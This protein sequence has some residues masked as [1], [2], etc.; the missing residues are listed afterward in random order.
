M[1]LVN[2]ASE[3]I[4]QIYFQRKKVEDVAQWRDAVQLNAG[5]MI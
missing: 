4:R 5:F 3:L 2:H 1:P